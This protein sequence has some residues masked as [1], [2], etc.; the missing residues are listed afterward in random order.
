VNSVRRFEKLHRDQRSRTG[1][2]PEAHQIIRNET[3]ALTG[4]LSATLEAS[5]KA[6]LLLQVRCCGLRS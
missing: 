5:P 4:G 2:G 6:L 3:Q 1:V